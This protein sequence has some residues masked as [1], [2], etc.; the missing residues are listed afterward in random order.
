MLKYIRSYNQKRKYIASESTVFPRMYSPEQRHIRG[1]TSWSGASTQETPSFGE[2]LSYFF[3]F[4][5]LS[6]NLSNHA[7]MLVTFATKLLG[8]LAIPCPAPGILT[9][10][11]ST[12]CNFNAA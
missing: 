11:D 9:M 4:S 5:S 10:A 3:S 8:R 6:R 7:N 1:Y 2:N 12:F